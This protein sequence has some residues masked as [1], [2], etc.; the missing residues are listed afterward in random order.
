VRL[1]RRLF[2][3]LISKCDLV[4]EDELKNLENKIEEINSI[5]KRI[6]TIKSEYSFLSLLWRSNFLSYLSIRVVLD[7]ILNIKSFDMKNLEKAI[8][9]DGHHHQHHHEDC[10][11]IEE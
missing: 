1:F 9:E 4:N 10:S 11:G 5:S 3:W 2:D 8:I 6:K 7:E